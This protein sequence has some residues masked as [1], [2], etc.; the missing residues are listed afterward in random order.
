ME[1]SDTTTT[2]KSNLTM[3]PHTSSYSRNPTAQPSTL[4]MYRTAGVDASGDKNNVTKIVASLSSI[5][6]LLGISIS[7]FV[8]QR[9]SRNAPRKLSDE[10]S[11]VYPPSSPLTSPRDSSPVIESNSTCDGILE[12]T[13]RNPQEVLVRHFQEDS[14]LI[15]MVLSDGMGERDESSNQ[16][17]SQPY[18]PLILSDDDYN[19]LIVSDMCSSNASAS[20]SNNTISHTSDS[21][22][23]TLSVLEKKTRDQRTWFSSIPSFYSGNDSKAFKRTWKE[24]QQSYPMQSLS[25]RHDVDMED[26]E[27]MTSFESNRLYGSN[28]GMSSVREYY[29]IDIPPL[30][31][32]GLIVESSGQ[33]PRILYVKP[34]SPFQG[35]VSEGDV[36]VEVDGISTV[37]MSSNE[38]SK[39][40]HHHESSGSSTITFRE[41]DT[42]TD[43]PAL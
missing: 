6:L 9:R 21:T 3:N 8:F 39:F 41:R 25:T 36:I 29:T 30:L 15:P 27:S 13:L 37:N 42:T 11:V 26:I 34:S 4:T 40:M 18:E 28:D 24:Q 17:S 2:F 1:A 5:M 38:L 35:L 43:I 10:E 22:A 32:L 31:P 20:S 14:V 7:C 12:I 23:S 33:G 19:R 16:S